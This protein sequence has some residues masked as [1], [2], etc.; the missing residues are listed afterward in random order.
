MIKASLKLQEN[1]NNLDRNFR[2]GDIVRHF[3][4]ETVSADERSAGK[5][6][7]IILNFADH[8]ETGE[9]LVIYQALYGDF[10]V[11]ARPYEMFVAEVDREK[12][13]DIKQKYRFETIQRRTS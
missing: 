8:T 6:L 12:H 9:K 1:G 5:Y 3:K 2:I 7:Y 10:G 11:Y 13:P 4:R